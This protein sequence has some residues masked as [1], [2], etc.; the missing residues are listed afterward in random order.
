MKRGNYKKKNTCF[1]II[2]S[3]NIVAALFLNNIVNVC[4]YNI[5]KNLRCL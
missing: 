3:K 4:I 2:F 1:L 5:A